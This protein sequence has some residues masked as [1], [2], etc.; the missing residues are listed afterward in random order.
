MDKPPSRDPPPR[1]RRRGEAKL[2][3][4]KLID[5]M[6]AAI[7]SLGSTEL[8]I[9]QLFDN[10]HD[11]DLDDLRCLLLD[12]GLN[13]SFSKVKYRDIASKVGLKFELGGR[14]MQTFD[15]HRARI[16]S[17]L[18][19]DIIGDL[20]VIMKQY[21]EPAR[22][23][24]V[25]A[26]S[27]SLAPLFNRIVALFDLTIFNTPESIIPGR[28][29]T[30]GRFE[31][32]FLVFGGLS[33]LVI[34]VKFFLGT[35]D[36][37]LDAIA[38]VIAESDA[39]DYA[40]DRLDLPPSV[41]YGILSDGISFEF[42]SFNGSAKPPIFSRGVFR[43]TPSSK[44]HQKLTVADYDATSD[45]DFIRSLRPI[46]ETI[47]YFLLMAYKA[48]VEERSAR[49]S[50]PSWVYAKEHAGEALALA[51]DAT[52]RAFARDDASSINHQT[53]KALECLRKSLVAVPACHK[54]EINLLCAWDE[55]DFTYC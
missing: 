37:R 32:H 39:C 13:V 43:T 53:E 8:A 45:A 14:D 50:Y 16:P 24:N 27:R 15:I 47:F 29:T 12:K 5:A 48:G 10:H 28:M 36:E 3:G 20:Q 7:S 34:E 31:Y 44:P 46:C 38:Q 54:T 55:E 25:E 33:V 4:G 19:K 17:P 23:K 6:D 40:N 51:V 49:E 35:A 42:F 1:K 2:T 22:H 18:F 26:R 41:I 21:G 11:V 52:T 30:R 9:L